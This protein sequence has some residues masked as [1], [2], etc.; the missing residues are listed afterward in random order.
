MGQI[1]NKNLYLHKHITDSASA[2]TTDTAYKLG[3]LSKAKATPIYA[4]AVLEGDD[5]VQERHKEV[6]G[7]DVEFEVTDITPDEVTLLDG[8]SNVSNLN[9]LDDASN[10]PYFG[11]SWEISLTSAVQQY[12]KLFKVKFERPETISETKKEGGISFYKAVLK[13]KAMKRIYTGDSSGVALFGCRIRSNDSNYTSAI[14]SG[15]HNTGG[16]GT[17]D[18]T[19]PTISS[20]VP[21]ADATDVA[22]TANYVWNFSLGIN[23]NLITSS[24]FFLCKESDG[25]IVAGALSYDADYDTITFNPT[26]SLANSTEYKAI[27]T[28]NVKTLAGT[29][30]AAN[31]VRTFTTVAP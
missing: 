17:L 3:A 6:M 25:S 23:P 28:T 2:F 19:A 31:S 27:V 1:G 18:A 30:L 20:T 13:G 21:D 9:V 12:E 24:N 15:W 26:S 29:A 7:Y 22:I 14:G 5:A 8:S 16:L 10:S 11:V 4:E